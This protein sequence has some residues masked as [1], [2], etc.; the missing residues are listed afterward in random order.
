MWSGG[1]GRDLLGG[2]F[3][4]LP[5]LAR[6]S[7]DAPTQAKPV[8]SSEGNLADPGDPG[9]MRGSNRVRSYRVGVV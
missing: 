3:S 2:G 9:G 8:G 7:R 5:G 1:G 6:L 4:V